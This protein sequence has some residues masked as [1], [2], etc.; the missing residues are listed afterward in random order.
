MKIGYRRLS[1]ALPLGREEQGT[2][3][4]WWE[5]RRGLLAT[6]RA[7]GHD[8]HLLSRLSKNAECDGEYQVLVGSGPWDL[9]MVEFGG[10]NRRFFGKDIDATLTLAREHR[11]PIVYLCDDPDLVF[12]WKELPEE[13]WSRWFFA[14]NALCARDLMPSGC[15]YLD[16]PFG[17]LNTAAR[18]LQDVEV[19]KHLAYIGRPNGRVRP[20]REIEASGAPVMIY[21]RDEEW[22]G[23]GFVVRPAPSQTERAAFYAAQRGCLAVADAKHKRLGWRTGRAYH[24]LAAGCPVVAEADHPALDW[25]FRYRRPCDLIVICKALADECYRDKAMKEQRARVGLDR[26]LADKALVALGL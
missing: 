20:F 14:A 18:E 24:A 21:G 17:A 8:V 19:G 13:D 11:G 5:K 12:P 1:G 9:L 2:R 3:G 7:R 16:M 15:S 10:A 26:T 6:L 4:A 23:F 22:A 25:A